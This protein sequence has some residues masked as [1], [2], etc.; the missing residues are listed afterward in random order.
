MKVDIQDVTDTRKTL[1]ISI[2]A[3]EIDAEESQ[4]LKQFVSQAKIPGF[5]PGKA[6][7]AMVR[8]RFAKQLGEELR[9]RILSKAYQEGSKESKLEIINPV[10]LADVEIAAGAPADIKFTVDIRPDFEITDYKGLEVKGLSEEVND[11]D[12]DEAVDAMRKERAEFSPVEREA[13]KGDYVKFSHEGAIDGKPISE[14]AP[15]KPVYA[16]MP[17]TWEEIGAENGLIP[18]LS[19]GLEGL[20]PGD[21]TEIEVEFP[22]DF[23]VE[24]LQGQ[25]AVYAVEVQEVRE[26]KLP[27]LDEAFFKA[28]GVKDLEDLRERVKSYVQGRKSQERRADIRRQVTE[29]ISAKVEMG[30]PE[31][32][33]EYETQI[34]MQQLVNDNARKGVSEDALEENKDE[35]FGRARAA[36]A[37]TVKLQLILTQVADKE[38]IKLEDQD[39]SRYVFERAY[40]TGQKP[41]ALA[42]E[43]RK[44]QDQLRRIQSSLLY[45]KTL[46]FLVDEAKVAGDQE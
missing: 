22:A 26:R 29:Q 42:K 6:P 20:K 30:L 41:E 25:K 12:V 16:K 38:E 1:A 14:I 10:D 40:Q 37:Q 27:D 31:S 19:H 34:A 39:L 44:D 46:E 33:V 43:L 32:L 7:D 13:A 2:E 28:Q 36:A 4:L 35:I 45:D 15:D 5:R 23:S 21:K 24:P 11:A 18:G 17:Q 8:K 3:S 9:Q